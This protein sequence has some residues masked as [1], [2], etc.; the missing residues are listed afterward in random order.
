M[1]IYKYKSLE[2]AE[3]HLQQLLPADPL[4]RLK[5]LQ[6]IVNFLKPPQRIERGVFRFSTLAEANA[7]RNSTL[8]QDPTASADG[9]N[10]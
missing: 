9:V 8:E 2:E 5:R 3:K 6:E 10:E 4:V 1:P 7:H